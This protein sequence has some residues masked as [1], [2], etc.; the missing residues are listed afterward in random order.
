MSYL[1]GVLELR[2]LISDTDGRKNASGKKLIGL[3]D[4]SNQ[5]FV[6]YDKRIVEDSLVVY[7]NNEVTR[8][9][10]LDATKGKLSLADAPG[11]NSKVTSDYSYQFWTDEELS[12]FLNKGAESCGQFSDSDMD[13]AYLRIEGG[14]RGAAL[15]LAAALAMKSELAYLINRRHSEEFNIEQDGNDDTGF[16]QTIDAMRR[17]AESYHKDGM[18]HRD[19]FYKRLGK[20]DL[21]SSKIKSPRAS[22]YGANR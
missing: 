5:N 19:D 12:N 1:K 7:I 13:Q 4:G 8:A 14:L 16:S 3:I 10:V 20:R 2:Q 15:Y 6:T 17:L 9:T 21:P 18:E 11:I 22:R